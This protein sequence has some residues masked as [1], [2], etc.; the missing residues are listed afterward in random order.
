MSD[1]DSKC[2][3]SAVCDT[4]GGGLGFDAHA[5]QAVVAR[6]QRAKDIA[7]GERDLCVA[8]IAK[9]ALACGNRAWL[10]LHDPADKNWDDDWRT[11]VFVEL[12]TGQMSWHIQDSEL[13][14]FAFLTDR[15][16]VLRA[17]WDGHTTEEKYDRLRAALALPG[18]ELNP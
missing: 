1:D 8:L 11:I 9:L 2:D 14:L 13:S 18:K 10:G 15:S 4:C 12:P 16:L 5:I 6:V 3:G 17:P 7:Y